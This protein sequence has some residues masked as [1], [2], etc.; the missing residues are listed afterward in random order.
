[1]TVV[2]SVAELVIVSSGSIQPK[3]SMMPN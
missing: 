3:D 1:V 2:V